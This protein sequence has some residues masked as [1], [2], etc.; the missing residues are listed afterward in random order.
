MRNIRKID[1]FELKNKGFVNIKN[2]FEKDEIDK[3]SLEINKIFPNTKKIDNQNTDNFSK[4]ALQEKKEAP[5]GEYLVPSKCH[6][7]TFVA[8][9]L[10]CSKLIDNLMLRLFNDKEFEKLCESLVGK[11]SKIFTF[12]YRVLNPEAK[13]LMLHQDDFC[14]LSFQIPLNNIRANDSSTCFVAGSH[15]S[16]FSLLD[17]FFG[18]ISKYLPKFFL[19]YCYTKY[20]A[21]VS[22]LGI[23]LNK[24]FHGTDMAKNLKSSKS[25]FIA[26]NAAGGHQHKKIYKA[27]L[28]TLY[29]E[30]FKSSIGEKIYNRL[31]GTNHL[32]K[33]HNKYFTFQEDDTSPEKIICLA[34]TNT[35]REVLCLDNT[36]KNNKNFV[37]QIIFF[38][39]ENISLKTQAII[40]YFKLII[41][42]KNL[43]KKLIRFRLSE[44]VKQ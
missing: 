15:L 34:K 9:I 4:S 8:P 36:I 2:F 39:E 35:G 33:F 22:D 17:N 12:H 40:C 18:S 6:E 44:K 26:I 31:F 13:S 28:K 42:T 29:N 20:T 14:Q 1:I 10:G 24:T 43:I 5:F 23:F 3:L 37:N 27:P 11:N 16:N 38:N 41:F 19:K 21:E 30:D 32:I 7:G 25:I